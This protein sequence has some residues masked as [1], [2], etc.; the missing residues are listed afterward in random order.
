MRFTHSP[1]KPLGPP[2]SWGRGP[3]GGAGLRAAL[4][5]A[6]GPGRRPALGVRQGDGASTVPPHTAHSQRQ[7]PTTTGHRACP[8]AQ[9]SHLQEATAQGK[10]GPGCCPAHS[11]LPRSPG[12]AWGS[13][14]DLAPAPRLARQVTQLFLDSCP[15]GGVHAHETQLRLACREEAG[16]RAQEEGSARTTGPGSATD[17]R[18][19]LDSDL[20]Q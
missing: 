4:L 17:Q 1:M 13:L 14:A 6:A 7:L 3:P 19:T 10:R 9:V 16:T 20:G 12:R 8:K 15:P 2:A 5:E 11:L 18:V